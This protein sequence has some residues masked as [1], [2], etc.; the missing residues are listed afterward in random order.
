MKRKSS[1]PAGRFAPSGTAS[2]T[3]ETSRERFSAQPADR[4]AR[5]RTAGRAR[6]GRFSWG[7][8]ENAKLMN[9]RCVSP[10]LRMLLGKL[11][12]FGASGKFSGSR[13]IACQPGYAVLR[14]YAAVDLQAGQVGLHL[15]AHAARGR[16]QLR[17]RSV[18]PS[19]STQQWS[20]PPVSAICGCEEG[21]GTRRL[22]GLRK[23]NGVPATGAISP[24]GT[25]FPLTGR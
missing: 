23:S 18:A 6:A 1:T 11:A 24:V 16:M 7:H 25:R 12:W 13:Q 17:R 21:G 19:S 2:S 20:N 10:G 22:F 15:H 8:R 5:R 14:W 9:E 4:F 3:N